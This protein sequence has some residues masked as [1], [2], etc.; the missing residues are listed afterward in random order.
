MRRT[1]PDD[2]WL[3]TAGWHLP[4]EALA[5][6]YLR[7]V[8]ILALALSRVNIRL[9]LRCA[10]QTKEGN[11]DESGSRKEEYSGGAERPCRKTLV[12]STSFELVTYRV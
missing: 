7:M 10:G 6:L 12:G 5:R 8:L 11:L 1:L 9:V 2:V 3:D 4:G